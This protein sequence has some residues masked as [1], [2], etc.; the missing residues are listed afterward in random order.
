MEARTGLES[1][2]DGA[3]L[4]E[5]CWHSALTEAKPPGQYEAHAY[6][7]TGRRSC[8]ALWPSGNA[9]AI[10]CGDSGHGSTLPQHYLDGLSTG[11][12]LKRPAGESM[13]TGRVLVRLRMDENTNGQGRDVSF[14]L[15]LSGTFPD[16]ICTLCR[17]GYKENADISPHEAGL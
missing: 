4:R 1:V 6:A 11:A 17:G 15:Q 16:I 10:M 8:P 2:S 9:L 14:V 5:A 7:R 3:F 12:K 13:R